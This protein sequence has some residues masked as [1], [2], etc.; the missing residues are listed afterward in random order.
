MSK[1][2]IENEYAQRI[3]FEDRLSSLCSRTQ[4]ILDEKDT[5]SSIDNHSRESLSRDLV[6]GAAS[7]QDTPGQSIINQPINAGVINLK[8]PPL[9]LPSFSGS[10]EQWP[11]FSDTFKSSVHNDQRHTDAQKLIYLSS[12][13]TG[14]AADK[15]E[16]LQT[17]D[18]NYQVAWGILEKS[19]DDPTCVINNHIK[20]F[21]ELASCN[22][23]SATALGELLNKVTKHYRALK[24]L[25]KP[26]LEAFPIYAVISKLDPQ[27]RIK[28]NEH[29]QSNSS[30]TMEQ[31]LEFLHA[32]EKI[33][34]TNKPFS[35]NEKSEKSGERN[36]NNSHTSNRQSQNQSN[37]R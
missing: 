29:V 2:D 3:E 14:R 6:S 32:R 26:F 11:G 36:G 37:Q 21:F 27:T 16:S 18:A 9:N 13:L 31:L 28:W 24:A 17:T 23:A 34:E 10:Y 22:N 33:L 1:E 19:Y 7:Q 20:S 5:S 15:I 35:K 30:P 4:T 12:C 25:R 8:L